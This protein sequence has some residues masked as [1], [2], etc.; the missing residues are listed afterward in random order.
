MTIQPKEESAVWVGGKRG[1]VR[2]RGACRHMLLSL[3]VT[4]TSTSTSRRSDYDCQYLVGVCNTICVSHRERKQANVISSPS[5]AA[6]TM[7][8]IASS[9]CFDLSFGEAAPSV[10]PS[11]T[12]AIKC[13]RCDFS[14]HRCKKRSTC[15][16]PTQANIPSARSRPIS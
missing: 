4:S 6:A 8:V 7:M 13:A 15:L 1:K 11:R 12:P 5:T 14:G 10:C 9:R 16:C 2:V 3:I